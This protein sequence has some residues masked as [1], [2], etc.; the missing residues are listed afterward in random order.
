M[1]L[2]TSES[3]GVRNDD[4]TAGAA[5]RRPGTQ[6]ILEGLARMEFLT[7]IFLPIA[8]VLLLLCAA[9]GNTRVF[10]SAVWGLLAFGLSAGLALLI[11]EAGNM[12]WGALLL[13]PVVIGIGLVVF[14]W[15]LLRSQFGKDAKKKATLP[16]GSRRLAAIAGALCLAG[17]VL[18]LHWDDIGEQ[19][20]RRAVANGNTTQLAWCLKTWDNDY[21]AWSALEEREPGPET[22]R[23]MTALLTARED[24]YSYYFGGAW[25]LL[26][27]QPAGPER[28]EV[29]RALQRRGHN[30]SIESFSALYDQKDGETFDLILQTADPEWVFS[31]LAQSERYDVAREVLDREP[32]RGDSGKLPQKIRDGIRLYDFLPD[33]ELLAR[34]L[35]AGVDPNAVDYYERSAL[36]LA[37]RDGNDG[38]ARLLLSAGADPC[39][40]DGEGRDALFYA[41]IFNR[42]AFFPPLLDACP[43]A[44]RDKAGLTPLHWAAWFGNSGMVEQFLARGVPADA[45]T[46][47]EFPTPLFYAVQGGGPRTLDLLLRMP[48]GRRPNPAAQGGDGEPTVLRAAAKGIPVYKLCDVLDPSRADFSERAYG[49]TPP[50]RGYGLQQEESSALERWRMIQAGK[51][52]TA[53]LLLLAGADAAR[54]LPNGDTILHAFFDTP[55]L[56]EVLEHRFGPSSSSYRNY[57]CRNSFDRVPAV[58]ATIE[59]EYGAML[60]TLL[61]AGAAPEGATAEEICAGDVLSRQVCLDVVAARPAKNGTLQP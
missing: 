54:V 49:L 11:A 30:V 22:L 6:T 8:G 25:D 46:P 42:E 57:W 53:S 38:A 56:D 18:L 31:S 26:V 17:C 50:E 59:R 12:G 36:L 13:I 39:L 55:G 4:E 47:P 16:S 7:Y 58:E 43:L 61:L 10:L 32:T 21:P 33:P 60:D 1:T 40:P 19:A 5:R 24:G 23:L 44:R 14:I 51:T 20:Y 34:L 3:S 35:A 28:L 15:H 52:K 2:D 37:L 27:R 29:A 45:G 9:F 48:E 41:V